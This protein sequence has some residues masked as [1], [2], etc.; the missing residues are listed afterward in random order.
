[1]NNNKNS[2]H[3]DHSCGHCNHEHDHC[4]VRQVEIENQSGFASENEELTRSCREFDEEEK[5]DK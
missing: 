3:D 1:M 5:E 4:D 2:R